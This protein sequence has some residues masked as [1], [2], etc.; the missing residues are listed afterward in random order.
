MGGRH[1]NLCRLM[2]ELWLRTRRLLEHLVLFVREQ[3]LL[4]G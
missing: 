1:I 2:T 3:T 4:L